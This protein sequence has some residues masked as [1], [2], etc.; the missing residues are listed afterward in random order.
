MANSG[1]TDVKVF[2]AG[3]PSWKEAELPMFGLE[4]TGGEFEVADGPNL[5]ITGVEFQ[6]KL[7]EGATVI[8][9]RDDDEVA[10]GMIDGAIHIPQGDILDD[11]EAIAGQL[12]DDKE[13][14]LLFH[15]AAGIRAQG[16]AEEVFEELG[17]ENVFYLDGSINIDADG[18]FSF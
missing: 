5:A 15:C 7:D 4:S 13:A 11:P 12:P 8:D 10:S 2:A 14:M 16:A 1:Y 3:I 9:V 17:Y 6:E 18:S